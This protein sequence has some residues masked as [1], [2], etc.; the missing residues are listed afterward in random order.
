MINSCESCWQICPSIRMTQELVALTALHQIYPMQSKYG[1]ILIVYSTTLH[2]FPLKHDFINSDLELWK[3]SCGGCRGKGSWSWQCLPRSLL[4]LVRTPWIQK[5]LQV[6][7]W[8]P[9]DT[10]CCSQWPMDPSDT[11]PGSKSAKP[12]HDRVHVTQPIFV[13]ASKEYDSNCDN[14]KSLL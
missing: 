14:E 11:Q 3:T 2:L 13:C 8:H 4:E 1:N 12:K 6:E 5:H 9:P 7:Q 10:T